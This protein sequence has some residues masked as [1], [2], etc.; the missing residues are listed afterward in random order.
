[1][2][3]DL[4][5][6]TGIFATNNAGKYIQQ[7]CKHFAH[8]IE[9]EYDAESGRCA[10]PTGPATLRSENGTLRIEI[11][12]ATGDDLERA[13][14]IIDNHLVRFAFREDFKGMDWQGA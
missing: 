8:K 4:R 14:Q 11:T 5:S 2:P 13:R 1:M 3:N 9:V 7:L 10:L 12:G 6:E